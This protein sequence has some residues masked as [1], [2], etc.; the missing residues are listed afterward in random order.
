[1]RNLAGSHIPRT[2][3]AQGQPLTG[4]HVVTIT[5]EEL[6]NFGGMLPRRSSPAATRVAE[7]YSSLTTD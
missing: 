6:Q 3:D 2:L 4:S 7:N 1:M 5:E